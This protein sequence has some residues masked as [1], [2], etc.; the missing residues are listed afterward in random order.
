M[1]CFKQKL[2]GRGE[3]FLL[4]S[5]GNLLAEEQLVQ[6]LLGVGKFVMFKE[7]C[8]GWCVY[9]QQA[10]GGTG[11]VGPGNSQGSQHAGP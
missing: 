11:E 8:L 7:Q 3:S 9:T 2:E 10:Q 5:D 6:S 4:S 1:S